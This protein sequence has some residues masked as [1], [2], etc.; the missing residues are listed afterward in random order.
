M[1]NR[2]G[3]HGPYMRPWY[4]NFQKNL[5]E[6]N[7]HFPKKL[8]KLLEDQMKISSLNA[9]I[10]GKKIQPLSADLI[11]AFS[12]LEND[13]IEYRNT[14]FRSRYRCFSSYSIQSSHFKRDDSILSKF[15]PQ[16]TFTSPL[17]PA[18]YQCRTKNLSHPWQ[19]KKC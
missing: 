12:R 15:N 19:L 17:Q 14:E 13:T 16:K 10:L 2:L 9:Y 5:V 3:T 11:S 6:S 18:R 8:I 7:C 4:N 1:G